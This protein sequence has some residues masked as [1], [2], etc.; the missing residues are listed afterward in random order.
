[1]M[2]RKGFIQKLE[3]RVVENT[4]AKLKKGKRILK[5]RAA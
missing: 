1:M 4:E 5:M 3:D 2:Q